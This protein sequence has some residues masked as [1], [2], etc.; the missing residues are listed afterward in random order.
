MRKSPPSPTFAPSSLSGLSQRI[1]G[2]R[3]RSNKA[4]IKEWAGSES[5]KGSL[6]KTMPSLGCPRCLQLPPLAFVLGAVLQPPT[7]PVPVRMSMDSG[8]IQTFPCLRRQVGLWINCLKGQPRVQQLKSYLRRRASGFAS[9]HYHFL[10][11]SPYA[12][13]SSPVEWGLVARTC[14]AD[15][16]NR[17]GSPEDT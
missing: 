9:R 3:L 4:F 2:E 11:V 14:R 10:P 5:D 13:A 12:S 7:D 6:P 1:R 8:H 15:V 17:Y 16:R